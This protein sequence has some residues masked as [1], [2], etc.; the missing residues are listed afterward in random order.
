MSDWKL[1]KGEGPWDFTKQP[2]KPHYN[3]G[4]EI[5]DAP[6]IGGSPVWRMDKHE[7]GDTPI[8]PTGHQP[9]C[10]YW[11]NNIIPYIPPLI[12]YEDYIYTIRGDLVL[13]AGTGDKDRCYKRLKSDLSEVTWY[14]SPGSG[15]NQLS[16]PFGICVDTTYAWI[17]DNVNN[18][19]MQRLKSDLSYVNKRTLYY[20][21]RACHASS[22]Q[23]WIARDSWNRV[24]EV[25]KVTLAT[26][27][28]TSLITT[29]KGYTPTPFDVTCDDLYLYVACQNPGFC[30]KVLNKNDLSY[31]TEFGT[32]E[33]WTGMATAL[34]VANGHLYVGDWWWC[35]LLK[36]NLSD[37]SVDVDMGVHYPIDGPNDYFYAP[38]AMIADA[39]RLFVSDYTRILVR[40]I[41]NLLHIAI[42]TDHISGITG[43][44]IN[45]SYIFAND[46]DTY[47]I[48]KYDI[49]TYAYIESSSTTLE[50]NLGVASDETYVYVLDQGDDDFRV[51]R[52][53]AA[54]LSYVD[55]YTDVGYSI[56]WN[57]LYLQVDAN[58]IYVTDNGSEGVHRIDKSTMTY[59]DFIALGSS[60]PLMQ[61]Y[62]DVTNS[63]VYATTQTQGSGVQKYSWPGGVFVNQAPDTRRDPNYWM[64][65]VGGITCDVDY[66]YIAD[67]ELNEIKIYDRLTRVYVD[68]FAVDDCTFHIA[69][70]DNYIYTARPGSL[71]DPLTSYIKKYSKISPYTEVDSEYERYARS[72]DT[73]YIYQV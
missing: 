54:D 48:H 50:Y 53:L 4:D 16:C 15:D 72:V 18:R 59:V 61:T 55:D 8:T 2:N 73:A 7:F 11:P 28:T 5:T 23:L 46:W 36:V 21:V 1:N 30:I 51:T 44:A 6:S 64:A 25:D 49:S 45:S 26:I 62:V 33:W 34:T 19:L 40:D 12:I 71:V 14:G 29:D 68:K 24:E 37:Y 9:W 58:Y 27:R 3:E 13:F 63:V 41:N 10:G 42:I 20:G 47:Q 43:V 56:F 66:L 38:D 39:T 57:P 70:D 60:S 67:A 31:V 52:L 17:C 35:D 32:P 65:Y 22:T 69:V